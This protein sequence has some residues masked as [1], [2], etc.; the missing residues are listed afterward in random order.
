MSRKIHPVLVAALAAAAFAAGCGDDDENDSGSGATATQA[1]TPAPAAT[2]EAAGIDEATLR[3]F[4]DAVNEDATVLCDP[5]NVTAE[6]LE[7]LGGEEA[8]K[9]A[10][11]EEPGGEEYTIDDLTI[12]GDTATAVI[13]DAEGTNTV[14]FVTEGD[15]I[16]VASSE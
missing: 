15:Q 6:L 4:I 8:C 14:T 16:K 5:D 12:E 11:A 9:T 1:A 10:A 2:E 13:T 7:S 3:E